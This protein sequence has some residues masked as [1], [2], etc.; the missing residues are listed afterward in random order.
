M[1]NKMS[2]LL[3]VSAVVLSAS[4]AS[5]DSYHRNHHRHHDRNA[6]TFD[7][8]TIAFG[9][10]DGYWDTGHRWHRWSNNRHRD[11][12]RNYQGN[13]Y[14]GWHHTRDRDNGWRDR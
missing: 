13:N 8:G 4:A 9:Y 10:N 1:L 7:F 2:L 12:Y 14:R 3:A 6:I 11:G 5:A